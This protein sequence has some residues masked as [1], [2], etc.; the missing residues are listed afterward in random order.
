MEAVKPTVQAH[1][2]DADAE[3]RKERE[4]VKWCER[5]DRKLNAKRSDYQPKR[6][7]RVD[8]R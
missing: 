4:A 5:L 3:A 2:A 6:R 1:D 7:R 8:R